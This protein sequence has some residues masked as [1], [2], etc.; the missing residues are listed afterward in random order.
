MAAANF[1]ISKHERIGHLR[2]VLLKAYFNGDCPFIWNY[3]QH[4]GQKAC[5]VEIS[6]EMALVSKLRDTMPSHGIRELNTRTYKPL[7]ITNPAGAPPSAIHNM[8]IK[9][10][11]KVKLDW[12]KGSISRGNP[13]TQAFFEKKVAEAEDALQSLLRHS[14]STPTEPR[15]KQTTNAL[16]RPRP[17]S[18]TSSDGTRQKQRKTH[19]TPDLMSGSDPAPNSPSG[20][21]REG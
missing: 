16:I 2:R 13:R 8:R 5:R 4:R 12:L 19:T 18:S 6:C 20:P 9:Q 14:I 10:V 7:D 1:L 17:L 21:N 3:N 11:R 15:S